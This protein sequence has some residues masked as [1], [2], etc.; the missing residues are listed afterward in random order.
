M[1]N[2]EDSKKVMAI[3]KKRFIL[4]ITILIILCCLAVYIFNK[5][6]NTTHPKEIAVKYNHSEVNKSEKITQKNQ[7]GEQYTPWTTKRTDGKKIAY[8][9]FDDG[10][11]VNTEKILHILNQNNI[12][13]SFFLIGKNAENN[14]DL[15]REEVAD[16][17]VIGNHTY[18]H[19]L[20]YKEGTTLFVNDINKCEK[21][22]KSIVGPSY[23]LNLVRFPGGSFG[24]KLVPFRTAVI[25]TGYK[26]IDWNDEIGDADGYDLPVSTL[27]NN[28][29][30]YTLQNTV[31]ILMHDAGA[32]KTTVEAL[33]QIIQ[34]LKLKGYSF[35][36][37]KQ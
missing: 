30:K 3:K 6:Y 16:G 37:L 8:L 36:T 32:K 26:F 19:Q 14:K 2:L 5:I 1:I 12:K 28:L 21:V 17:E 7:L 34:Y 31:V 18:S 9:T 22:L 27:L 13:A 11:S 33:P 20:N 4:V 25:K 15:V 35:D 10:P 29:K 24:P 23:N